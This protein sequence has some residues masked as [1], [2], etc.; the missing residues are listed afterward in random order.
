[1]DLHK[2]AGDKEEEA[3]E[4]AKRRKCGQKIYQ[5]RYKILW[6]AQCIIS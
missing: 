2:C 3:E 4:R 1:M 6:L 5:K